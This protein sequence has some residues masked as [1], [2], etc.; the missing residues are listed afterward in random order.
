MWKRLVES[1]LLTDGI[2]NSNLKAL[3][4]AQLHQN[5]YPNIFMS[6]VGC[7]FL[8]TPFQ[9][10]KSQHKATVLAE[11]AQTVG[12]GVNS[13][14]VKLLEEDSQTLKDLL[15]D[16][17]ALAKEAGMRLFCFFEQHES[18]MMKLLSK[19]VPIKHKVM[20]RPKNPAV[21]NVC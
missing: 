10:T 21:C 1:G 9:G 12:L 17:V 3:L 8:G 2:V 7:V 19:N 16:F 18:D 13:G 5:D 4:T 15:D 20:K 14:L 11:M 6:V